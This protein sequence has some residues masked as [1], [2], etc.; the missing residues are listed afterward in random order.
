VKEGRIQFVADE[1]ADKNALIGGTVYF[2]VIDT[3]GA[4]EDD[5]WVR[6]GKGLTEAFVPGKDSEGV[7]SPAFDSSARYLYLYQTVNDLPQAQSAMRSSSV[8][9]ID[10]ML[11]TSWGHFTGHGF[12]I[13]VEQM[14]KSVIQPV[15]FDS[16]A[17][18]QNR[19]YR[20]PDRE[21]LID[22]LFRIGKY[23]SRPKDGV[24]QPVAGEDPVR[25]PDNVVLVR[26]SDWYYRSAVWAFGLDLLNRAPA[27]VRE[28]DFPD[29]PRIRPNWIGKNLLQPK[30][31]GALF[32]FTSPFPP[33]Y[34]DVRLRGVRVLEAGGVRPI[35]FEGGVIPAADGSAPVGRVPTPTPP[36]AGA[37]AAVGGILGGGI[38]TGGGGAIG[39]G[40]PLGGA[41]LLARPGFIGSGL[42]TTGSST[43][44]QQIPQQQNQTQNQSQ[45]QAPASSPAGS[46]TPFSSPPG[47]VVPAPS[48]ALLALI[49]VPFLFLLWRWHGRRLQHCA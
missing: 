26:G 23:P 48:S 1:G 30:E 21:H 4:E 28:A 10:P 45:T 41:G 14:G 8:L 37:V 49:G 35:A 9:L 6:I 46:V 17:D 20:N 32:G 22:Q 25:N 38:L 11:V 44:P 31:R 2:T 16:P 36:A 40:L 15:S 29:R 39:G 34:D 24:I 7:A 18:A 13:P 5:L 47:S 27:R 19:V 42:G 33:T 43:S 3:T 12:A